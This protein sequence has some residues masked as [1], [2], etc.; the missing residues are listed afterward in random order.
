[1][2]RMMIV[3]L[4]VFVLACVGCKPNDDE[5]LGAELARIQREE[6]A[7]DPT[8][9]HAGVRKMRD[10]E[11]TLG[12]NMMCTYKIVSNKN[13]EVRVIYIIKNMSDGR[14]LSAGEISESIELGTG[15]V[16]ASRMS[17]T[18][19]EKC[20]VKVKETLMGLSERCRKVEV[21]FGEGVCSF[22]YSYRA[23]E[24]FSVL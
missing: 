9:V 19:G 6:L 24:S 7:T 13:G 23:G 4:V 21:E 10:R 5:I 22:Q 1:M 12:C 20:N 17:T 14:I 11:T 2:N 16:K 18:C 8:I 3:V 15:D